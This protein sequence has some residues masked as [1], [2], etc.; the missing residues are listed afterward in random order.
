MAAQSAGG[1]SRAAGG[2]GWLGYAGHPPAFWEATI[3]AD[4]VIHRHGLVAPFPFRGSGLVA[5]RLEGAV[6]V[7][8][9]EAACSPVRVAHAARTGSRS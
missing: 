6:A 5:G 7:G 3:G 2:G 8:S 1:A 4:R 9:W